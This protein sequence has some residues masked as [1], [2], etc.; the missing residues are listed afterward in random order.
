MTVLGFFLQK[1]KMISISILK[2]NFFRFLIVKNRKYSCSNL[3]INAPLISKLRSLSLFE[4]HQCLNMA[5]AGLKKT[6][7]Q[8]ITFT[9]KI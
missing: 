7:I 3:E 9:I 2:I 5:A 8:L 1:F 4:F 6:L